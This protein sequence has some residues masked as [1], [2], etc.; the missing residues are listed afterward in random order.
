[1]SWFGFGKKNN[2]RDWKKEGIYS[3]GANENSTNVV[4]GLNGS[5]YV[6]ATKNR[7]N[8]SKRK[9]TGYFGTAGQG[10]LYGRKGILEGKGTYYNRLFTKRNRAKKLGFNSKNGI[11]ETGF[12]EP[13]TAE[14][15][16]SNVRQKTAEQN[17]LLRLS[18]NVENSIIKEG[19][20]PLNLKDYQL[21]LENPSITEDEAILL[22]NELICLFIMYLLYIRL[23]IEYGNDNPGAMEN[24]PRP[25]DFMEKLSPKTS[26][27][28][29]IKSGLYFPV[30]TL[31]KVIA[32]CSVVFAYQVYQT[33]KKDIVDEKL[34]AVTESNIQN[35]SLVG[36][37]AEIHA[38]IVSISNTLPLRAVLLKLKYWGLDSNQVN[39]LLTITPNIADQSYKGGSDYDRLKKRAQIDNST[40][41]S[42]VALDYA[43]NNLNGILTVSTENYKVY[44]NQLLELL[45]TDKEMLF[46]LLFICLPKSP[47]QAPNEP[48]PLLTYLDLNQR[49]INEKGIPNSNFV[50]ENQTMQKKLRNGTIVTLT[51][52]PN[53][54]DE[55]RPKS[56]LEE[57]VIKAAATATENATED[58]P[59]SPPVPVYTRSTPVATA[60]EEEYTDI[61]DET[62]SIKDAFKKIND[63]L[64]ATR[65]KLRNRGIT[66][67]R[68]Y[69]K[70]NNM[71]KDAPLLFRLFECLQISR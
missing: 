56:Y 65:Q 63:Y 4:T 21:R 12:V 19:S 31:Y 51:R 2:T 5:I 35:K 52:Q 64:L 22:Y 28:S 54:N 11:Q 71:I 44:T 32:V 36:V 10:L 41:L 45:K 55:K 14:N 39:Y 43:K 50:S 18:L 20:T 24:I 60:Y 38:I 17:F 40:K 15:N 30:K 57:E 37:L 1:M 3:F 6:N 48:L 34:K 67:L 46:C 7:A 62:K 29:K 33:Y 70:D 58:F 61:S 68:K 69:M 26:Y 9:R 27:F 8:M 47:Y 16:I 23:I 49:T 66:S 59:A 42:L 25:V 53:I 13:Q